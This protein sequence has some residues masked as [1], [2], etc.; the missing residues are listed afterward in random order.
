MSMTRCRAAVQRCPV[1]M[2]GVRRE[3]SAP[4]FPW[5]RG[6]EAPDGQPRGH[7]L[8]RAKAQPCCR[9]AGGAEAAAAGPARR[10]PHRHASLL[11]PSIDSINMVCEHSNTMQARS[12]TTDAG[13]AREST[14]FCACEY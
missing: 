2:G 12:I 14:L 5:Q 7:A 9:Q 8:A 1:A 3:H 13:S 11:S 4:S 10:Q 6:Q